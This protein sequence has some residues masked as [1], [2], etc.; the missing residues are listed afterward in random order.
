[1]NLFNQFKI[2]W[3]TLTISSHQMALFF[4][5]FATL[6]TAGITVLAAC[7][8]LEKNQ[9]HAALQRII[10]NIKHDILT[11]KSLYAAMRHYPMQFN[12]LT[13]QLIHIGEQTGKLEV[14]L[15]AIAHHQEKK[16]ALHRQI[17]QQLFYPCI[18][19]IVACLISVF[20]LL[21]IIPR[22]AEIF[23]NTQVQLPLVTRWLFIFATTLQ[24][25]D[26]WL[27]A[28]P[29]FVM[30]VFYYFRTHPHKYVKF[31][32]QLYEH[33]PILKHWILSMHIAQFAR[34]LALMLAA[35]ITITD[36]L[37][38]CV[39]TTHH[40]P[41]F[42]TLH[43]LHANITAGVPLH[44]AFAKLRCFPPLLIQMTKVG[45]ESGMLDHML[46]KAAD[47]LEADLELTLG[48][49]TQLLEPLIM[50]I[51]GALIGGTV[52]SLYLPIFKLGS[53]F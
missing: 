53:V 33:L 24:Q 41:F 5:Q 39:S 10:I 37:R 46:G 28:I 15:N 16:L 36:A 9:T 21:F 34:Q 7:S 48:R 14:V 35:G 30:G 50:L 32:R 27:M 31:I 47:L 29:L 45:E 17:K 23:A 52:I 40:Q 42:M 49:L 25:Y 12:P 4:R 19:S 20:L 6:L 22:F 26:Q 13:L 44:H 11:G 2:K 1:M 43:Q 3:K 8:L 38:V 18:I 51:L